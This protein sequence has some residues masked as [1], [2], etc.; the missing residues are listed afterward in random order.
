MYKMILVHLSTSKERIVKVLP[1][2]KI[3]GT[4]CKELC[5]RLKKE[6]EGGQRTRLCTGN[7]GGGMMMF[8]KVLVKT[9]RKLSK[10]KKKS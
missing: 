3:T 7:D 6:V 1:L 4:F 10:S 9:I 8:V 5:K 2:L